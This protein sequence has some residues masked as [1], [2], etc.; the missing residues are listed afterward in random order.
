MFELEV[1]GDFAA[2]HFLRGYKGKCEKLHGHN[3]LVRLTLCGD[4]L[5]QQGM[6]IDFS[7][8]RGLLS[9]SLLEF[10]HTS[11]NDLELFK[12]QNPTTENIAKAVHEQ[13]SA[14]LPEGVRIRRV[15]VWETPGSS[16]SYSPA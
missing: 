11:L 6:L 12:T 13:V 9:Q 3:W 15:T 2:A 10:D 16:A 8:A 1:E 7:D 5:T 14:K 4:R